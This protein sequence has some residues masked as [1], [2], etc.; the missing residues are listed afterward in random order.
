MFQK[1]LGVNLAKISTC[2]EED[3]FA[4]RCA[5]APE[6]DLMQ[7]VCYRQGLVFAQ[8]NK[9]DVIFWGFCPL[10]F[11]ITKW[12]HCIARKVTVARP[13]FPSIFTL[14]AAFPIQPS[15]NTWFCFGEMNSYTYIFSLNS[16]FRST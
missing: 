3:L 5:E 13:R 10:S 14:D 1:Q 6:A 8:G 15:R 9:A 12:F 2:Q 4:S 7:S 16:R 11:V